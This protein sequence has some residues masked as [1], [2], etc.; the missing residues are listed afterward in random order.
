MTIGQCGRAV[1]VLSVRG[2][3]GSTARQTAYRYLHAGTGRGATWGRPPGNPTHAAPRA[4]LELNNPMRVGSLIRNATARVSNGEARRRSCYVAPNICSN[5]PLFR[6]AVESTCRSTLL[7]SRRRHSAALIDGGRVRILK[8]VPAPA[9]GERRPTL[10]FG[11]K[12]ATV[13]GGA[14]NEIPAAPRIVDCSR[15]WPRQDFS[16]NGTAATRIAARMIDMFG[17]APSSSLFGSV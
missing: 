8:G 7:R 11:K 17:S 14:S 15:A 2:A 4:A 1:R 10:F 5:A 6:P 13:A 12:C 16:T 9:A 3:A